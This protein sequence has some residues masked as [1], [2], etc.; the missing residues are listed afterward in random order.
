MFLL[1]GVIGLVL[2]VS[3]VAILIL[4][5]KYF[6]QKREYQTL[7]VIGGGGGGNEEDEDEEHNVESA[8]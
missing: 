6:L 7:G 5:R 8:D 3:L 1:V 2:V 4:T